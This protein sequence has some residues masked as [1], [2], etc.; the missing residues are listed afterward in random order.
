MLH[1][2]DM[3]K[4]QKL[5][6]FLLTQLSCSYWEVNYSK[7]YHGNTLFRDLKDLAALPKVLRKNP[8][9]QRNLTSLE[10]PSRTSLGYQSQPYQHIGYI[11]P[12]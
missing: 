12:C 6:Y 4:A 3:M 8:L 2:F 1:S 11:S 5:Y 10:V 9:P 7:T